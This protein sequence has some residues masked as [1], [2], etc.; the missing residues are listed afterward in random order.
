MVRVVGCLLA[1]MKATKRAYTP[2]GASQRL[3][4]TQSLRSD[5]LCLTSRTLTELQ[6]AAVTTAGKQHDVQHKSTLTAIIS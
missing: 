4:G 3:L 6:L 5:S 1:Q 2:G